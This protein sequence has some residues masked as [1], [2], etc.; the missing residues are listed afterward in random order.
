MLSV[1][2]SGGATIGDDYRLMELEIRHAPN[3]HGTALVVI[4]LSVEVCKKF[5]EQA[6]IQSKIKLLA[7]K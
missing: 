4:R 2:V 1:E 6:N 5:M 7:K 3:E